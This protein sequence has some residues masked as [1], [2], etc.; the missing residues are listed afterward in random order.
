[1]P[2]L[3]RF[4][5]VITQSSESENESEIHKA[6]LRL[7]ALNL[8]VSEDADRLLERLRL[9]RA[10]HARLAT[11]ARVRSALQNCA[12]LP[13]KAEWHLQ[14][15]RHGA[16]ALHD[17]LALLR[18]EN[19]AR[20]SDQDWAALIDLAQAT[21]EPVLPFRGA[22]LIARGIAKGPQ[23]RSIL[24]Q[25]EQDWIAAGYTQDARK[26]ETMLTH[27]TQVKSTN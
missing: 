12:G 17:G 7:A 24:A 26:I 1:M 5:H 15:Y 3:S 19:R 11:A 2:H 6:L 23:I 18:A 27:R 9:S 13:E 21:P 25:L 22:D 8:D 20:A 14:L 4:E 16:Q 10:E